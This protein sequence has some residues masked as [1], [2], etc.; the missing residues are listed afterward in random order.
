MKDPS[1]RHTESGRSL[2]RL[3]SARALAPSDWSGLTESIPS[4]C[5]HAVSDIAE[6]YAAMWH[7]FSEE[8][9]QVPWA[10]GR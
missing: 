8:L 5:V 3:L 2:L 4:H 1:L 10:S 6:H 7:R 9:R